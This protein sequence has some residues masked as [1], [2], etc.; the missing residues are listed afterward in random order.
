M[1]KRLTLRQLCKL[2][3]LVVLHL[4]LWFMYDLCYLRSVSRYIYH[5][6]YFVNH[7]SPETRVMHVEI[8]TLDD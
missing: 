1:A 6:L 8:Q 4:V 3:K 7:R 2:Y 5:E